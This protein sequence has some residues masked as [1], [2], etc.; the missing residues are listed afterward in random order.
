MD[1]DGALTQQ[2]FLI[3]THLISKTRQV[4]S[5][6]SITHSYTLSQDQHEDLVS[7]S[8]IKGVPLPETVPTALVASAAS[9]ARSQ[10]CFF[11]IAFYSFSSHLNSS[12]III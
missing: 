7:F 5:I 11:L 12:I 9:T 10:N 6:L 1:K 3:A 4:R 2:E 8:V